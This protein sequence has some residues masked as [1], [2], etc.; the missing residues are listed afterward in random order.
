MKGLITYLN[1][2]GQTKEA[3]TFYNKCFGGD[4]YLMPFGEIP[5]GC[6]PEAKDRTMHASISKNGV[7]VLMASDS[8]PGMPIQQGN[9]CWVN[10]NCESLDEIERLFV[11][12]G[13]GGAVRMPLDNQFWG[14]RFGML[15]DRFGVQWMF[16]YE[17][18]K[19]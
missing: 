13:E 11:Q 3:I 18:P 7:S 1:F 9:N 6:A 10:V 16:N 15:T 14:A 17:L 8:P 2:D 12:M 4:L 5:G 19:G